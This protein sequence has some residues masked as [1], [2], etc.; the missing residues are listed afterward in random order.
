MRV[1]ERGQVFDSG[2][3]GEGVL[4]LLA[5]AHA[6]LLTPDCT[7]VSSQWRPCCAFAQ[8]HFQIQIAKIAPLRYHHGDRE[9]RQACEV[10]ERLRT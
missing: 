10:L 6:R 1:A 8:Q 2:L 7:L 3:M 9:E 5:W 4:H